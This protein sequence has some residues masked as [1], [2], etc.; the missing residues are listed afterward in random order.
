M[1]L[2]KEYI[3]YR[4]HEWFREMLLAIGFRTNFEDGGEFL[5]EYCEKLEN[6]LRCQHE[7]EVI[8]LLRTKRG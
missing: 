7:E 6:D 3:P 8:A 1:A 5:E 4:A 2:E